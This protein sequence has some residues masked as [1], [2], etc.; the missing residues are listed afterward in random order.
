MVSWGDYLFSS[1]H[2]HQELDSYEWFTILKSEL[3]SNT[4]IPV[5]LAVK[6][7]K[8]YMGSVVKDKIRSSRQI[9]YR[10][11]NQEINLLG[12][13]GTITTNS[14]IDDRKSMRNEEYNDYSI[15]QFGAIPTATTVGSVVPNTNGLG[16]INIKNKDN[17]E[18][19]EDQFKN[20]SYEA[21]NAFLS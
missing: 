15:D 11:I 12:T 8:E 16:G 6:Y 4:T 10:G 19:W 14:S 17:N 18:L 3:D 9:F 20:I 13:T 7:G 21:V 1:D 2:L 5:D